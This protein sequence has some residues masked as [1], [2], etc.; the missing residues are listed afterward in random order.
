[1]DITTKSNYNSSSSDRYTLH[2]SNTSTEQQL[3]DSHQS[4]ANSFTALIQPPLDLNNLMYLRAHD[5]DLKLE[6]LNIDSVPLIFQKNNSEII[7]TKLVIDSSLCRDNFIVDKDELHEENQKQLE[8]ALDDFHT[9]QPS[10]ALNFLNEILENSSNLFIIK[11]YLEVVADDN[12]IFQNQIFEGLSADKS[13]DEDIT[14]HDLNMI[15]RYTE[16]ALFARIEI[17][18]H[19]NMLTHPPV[20]PSK[21]PTRKLTDLLDPRIPYRFDNGLDRTREERI[22][23]ASKVLNSPQK[24][25]HYNDTLGIRT[26]PSIKLIDLTN[27]YDIN[28]KRLTD[29]QKE[30]KSDEIKSA[31]HAWLSVA[32]KLGKQAN[33]QLTADNRQYLETWQNSNLNIIKMGRKLLEL[34]FNAKERQMRPNSKIF[35]RPFLAL[36]LDRSHLKCQFHINRDKLV[37]KCS[38]TVKFPP[39]ASYK[40]GSSLQ[41]NQENENKINKVVVGPI[42]LTKQSNIAMYTNII[43]SDRQKL[44]SSIRFSPQLLCVKSPILAETARESERSILFSSDSDFITFFQMPLKLNKYGTNIISTTASH[45]KIHQDFFKVHRNHNILSQ[46]KIRITDENNIDFR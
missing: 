10:K 15:F 43:V 23:F 31:L 32:G 2:I 12:S 19:L 3:M 18:K 6:N 46:I 40:L 37:D 8:V 22:L 41:E 42:T 36:S 20:P 45:G 28:F 35:N 30:K 21:S 4:S 11:R 29:K 27:Y 16:I 9:L 24:R 13:I 38:L 17:S 7:K 25:T 39:Y 33:G 34:T 14:T 26:S 44:F 1:M 5:T